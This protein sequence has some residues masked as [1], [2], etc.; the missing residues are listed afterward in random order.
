MRWLRW[1]GVTVK[2]GWLFIVKKAK[3]L[4]RGGGGKVFI[5]LF[6]S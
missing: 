1:E 3:M 4:K 2:G 5:T 6:F